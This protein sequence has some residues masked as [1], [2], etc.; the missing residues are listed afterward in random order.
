[1]SG[2]FRLCFVSIR[3]R[4]NRWRIGC[5][6][7]FTS[8]LCREPSTIASTPTPT[9]GKWPFMENANSNFYFLLACRLHYVFRPDPNTDAVDHKET[10][11]NIILCIALVSDRP[12]EQISVWMV[13]IH[14][15]SLC[16]AYESLR[17]PSRLSAMVTKGGMSSFE[18]DLKPAITNG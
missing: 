2:M 12:H 10:I 18:N 17:R 11:E 4:F 1:M 8:L 13:L 5:I 15:E 9:N 6:L 14:K 7:W 16:L 3:M